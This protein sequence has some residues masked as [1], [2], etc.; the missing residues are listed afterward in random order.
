MFAILLMLQKKKD[1]HSCT[2]FLWA[3]NFNLIVSKVVVT[4]AS[5]MK[6][7]HWRYISRSWKEVLKM[8]HLRMMTR[9][10]VWY[11]EGTEKKLSSQLGRFIYPSVKRT[12]L[13]LQTPLAASNFFI[14]W[15]LGKK[16]ASH[17]KRDFTGSL[18]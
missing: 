1:R 16:V 11:A 2:I 10:T 15:P 12:A 17:F 5:L 9:P 18:T 6:W 13:V 4:L 7:I 3:F 8:V 14:D